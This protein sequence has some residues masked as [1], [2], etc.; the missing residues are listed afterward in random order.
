MKVVIIN[1]NKLKTKLNSAD[2]LFN[3]AEI[4]VVHEVIV[5]NK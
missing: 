1:R 5:D 4:V 2:S 3:S